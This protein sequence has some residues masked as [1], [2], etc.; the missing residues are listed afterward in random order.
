MPKP[1]YYLILEIPRTASIDEVKQGYRR[2]ALKYHPDTGS[3]PDDGKDFH[4]IQ[5]A[6]ETL[7]NLKTKQ[8]YDKELKRQE[9][10]EKRKRKD[11][12]FRVQ[13][14]I[15]EEEKEKPASSA[16]AAANAGAGE[17]RKRKPSIIDSIWDSL[18]FSRADLVD[19]GTK[20]DEKQKKTPSENGSLAD[21]LRGVRTIYQRIDALESV[22]G[23]TRE[24]SID[25]G[26]KVR[27]ETIR[28]PAGILDG[29][30]LELTFPEKNEFPRQTVKVRIG[31]VPHLLVE[32]E[33]WDLT[34]KLPV[35]PSE[36]LKGAELEVPSLTGPVKVR[37]PEGWDARK[38]LRIKSR[39]V[40][41]PNS[42]TTGDLYVKVLL[43]M[44]N[45]EEQAAR[46]AIDNLDQYYPENVRKDIPTE[47]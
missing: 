18:G 13:A 34:V 36:L 21:R 42:G 24:I 10:A 47:L 31:I 29:T 9:G 12:T 44:P 28:I 5:T 17:A 43:V 45:V 23:T 11:S 41:D 37:L 4:I 19:E 32:R 14:T 40:K 27:K 25:Q 38:R 35:K 46:D 7:S 39:G 6:Y 2:L 16:S 8:Q 30:M 20:Q 22:K 15:L 1:D 33:G 3:N 26:G